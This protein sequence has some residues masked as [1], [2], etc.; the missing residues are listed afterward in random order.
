M[1]IEYVTHASLWIQDRDVSLLT[2]PFFFLEPLLSSLMDHFP[3]REIDPTTFGRIRY[4]YSSHLHP[5]HCHPPTLARLKEHIQTVLLP[6]ERPELEQRYRNLGYTDIVILNNGESRCLEDGLEVTSFWSDPVDSVL[7]VRTKDVT[8]LHQNDCFLN[9]RTL[10]EIASRFSIDCLFL[11]YTQA[12]NFFPLLLDRPDPELEALTRQ[13]EEWSFSY[14]LDVLD[15]LRPRTV[16]PYSMTMTYI[17]P[18]QLRLNGYG[19]LTPVTFSER[20]RKIRPNISCLIMQPGDAID[21]PSGM[22]RRCREENLW[23]SN[24]DE[25][26]ENVSRHAASLTGRTSQWRPG[27]PQVCHA[28]L[29]QL[30]QIPARKQV[31]AWLEGQTLILH[32]VGDTDAKISYEID[33]ASR[34]ICVVEP[35]ARLARVPTLEVTVPAVIVSGLLEGEYDPYTVLSSYKIGFKS[36]RQ[37]LDPQSDLIQRLEAMLLLFQRDGHPH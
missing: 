16:V 2:D 6:A 19:R 18:D 10:K 31:P 13:K 33:F 8:I 5:D 3:P 25:Y 35:Q 15:C 7:V 20:L 29:L 23:G 22:V 26:L 37:S 32:V 14:N 28:P 1:R 21:L 34:S 30:L 36:H 11:L 24:L 4:V 17:Q 12:Q 9:Q 27:N